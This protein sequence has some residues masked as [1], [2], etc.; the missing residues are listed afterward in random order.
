MWLSVITNLVAHSGFQYKYAPVRS[1]R[2]DRSKEHP[3]P[4]ISIQ[5]RLHVDDATGFMLGGGI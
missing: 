4:I 5:Q 1:R 2:G 3:T